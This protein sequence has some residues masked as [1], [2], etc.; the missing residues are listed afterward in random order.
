MWVLTLL[1]L[2]VNVSIEF[3][4]ENRLDSEG[5][6]RRCNSTHNNDLIIFPAVYILYI[7]LIVIFF[8]CP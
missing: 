1:N 3:S 7:N 2:G 6:T 8:P 5:V 4:I